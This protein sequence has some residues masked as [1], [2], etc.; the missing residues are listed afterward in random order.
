[1][2]VAGST[3]VSEDL[4]V[5]WENSV[6]DAISVFRVIGQVKEM[7]TGN[8][9]EIQ[10]IFVTRMKKCPPPIQPQ[11]N[12]YSRSLLTGKTKING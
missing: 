9:N 8:F 10:L 2:W 7:M 6:V 5:V 11:A 4:K 12:R 1:M 3:S